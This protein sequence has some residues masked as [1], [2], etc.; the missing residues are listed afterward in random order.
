MR[1]G[2]PKNGD[3]PAPL[4]VAEMTLRLWESFFVFSKHVSAHE[5]CRKHN[6]EAE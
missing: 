3:M 2:N 5:N 4:L 6:Q 1:D